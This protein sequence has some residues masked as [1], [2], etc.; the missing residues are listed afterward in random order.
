[1]G[2]PQQ[3]GIKFEFGATNPHKQPHLSFLPSFHSSIH[4]PIL[5]SFQ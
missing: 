2:T 1:M 3:Q 4:P 5:C